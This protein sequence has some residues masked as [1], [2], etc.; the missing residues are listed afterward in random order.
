MMSTKVDTQNL[1][2]T[3][4]EIFPDDELFERYEDELLVLF[5]EHGFGGS[6]VTRDLM[7]GSPEIP[8]PSFNLGIN[9]HIQC[10][11][12]QKTMKVKA[13]ITSSDDQVKPLR[14][15][16]HEWSLT[17]FDRPEDFV[18][19]SE[20]GETVTQ[21]IIETLV[22]TMNVDGRVING[23]VDVL[24]YEEVF[25][26]PSS[27]QRF[28]F[29]TNIL[30]DGVTFYYMHDFNKRFE[31]FHRNLR[32]AANNNEDAVNMKNLNMVFFPLSRG[33]QLY[34]VVL[35][36]KT[37][38]VEIIDSSARDGQIDDV[39]DYDVSILQTMMIRHLKLLAHCAGE[40]LEGV[41][42][43]RLE[44]T[45]RTKNDR[46]NSGVFLMRHM[47]TYMGE[48]GRRWNA[49]LDKEGQ[50]Q[51]RQL[52]ILRKKYTAKMVLSDN[53]KRKGFVES[54]IARFNALD[55]A[56]RGQIAERA[57]TTRRQ[58]LRSIIF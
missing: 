1:I 24:N 19:A 35:N 5:N 3:A 28:F 29:K 42:Q 21:A 11:D 58:R 4:K 8:I 2:R 44:M 49:G 37:P 16:V 43:K 20:T 54:Y 34:C 23:W 17:A 53:N 48:A 14:R 6:S 47:E 13:P 12:H 51:L 32:W 22:A 33:S 15:E 25:R 45:W 9:Q 50:T 31:L 40:L 26:S 57:D 18:Y 41:E 38:S 56:S 7:D 36:L 27:P 39:Y 46:I 52:A 55:K 10:D 30:A